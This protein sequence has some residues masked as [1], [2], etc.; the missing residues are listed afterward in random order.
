MRDGRWKE[1]RSPLPNLTGRKL[2]IF[3]LGHIGK[4]MARRGLGFEME[5]GYFSRTRQADIPYHCFDRLADLAAWC[6]VLMVAAPGG[7]GTTRSWSAQ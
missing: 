2:G 7:P 5:I 3:G 4:A 6:D 1:L